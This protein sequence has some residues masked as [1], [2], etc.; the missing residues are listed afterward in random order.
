MKAILKKSD[1][2]RHGS[3]KG[4]PARHLWSRCDSN[5]CPPGVVR[6]PNPPEKHQQPRG[7]G[8]DSVSLRRLRLPGATPSP[9]CQAHT[10]RLVREEPTASLGRRGGAGASLRAGHHPR[11]CPR[12]EECLPSASSLP[13][14]RE[15]CQEGKPRGWGWGGL[16]R[17]PGTAT[18]DKVG[19]HGEFRFS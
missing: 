5:W 14:L 7:L 13:A 11:A 16:P 12:G 19:H 4:A 3:Q 2:C 15:R 8:N 10:D 1:S 17:D 9:L 6:D 18:R